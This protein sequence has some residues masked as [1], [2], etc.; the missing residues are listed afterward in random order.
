MGFL[1]TF[2]ATGTLFL[3]V[4]A[5]WG[6]DALP[7]LQ[8]NQIPSLSSV[9]MTVINPTDVSLSVTCYL[10]NP[11]N[12]DSQ[13]SI[14]VTSAASAG[15]TCNSM[16]FVCKGRCFGCYSDF[17]LSEDICVDNAGRKFLR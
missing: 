6:D 17:D 4:V 14:I 10:G 5:A 12:N 1:N 15:P 3:C 2:C 7:S 11:L 16:F 13:G 8:S 9:P